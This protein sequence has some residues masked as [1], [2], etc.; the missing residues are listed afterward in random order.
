M[1]F[2]WSFSS[3]FFPKQTHT[4]NYKYSQFV[5]VMFIKL[6][7]FNFYASFQ[8]NFV[9][10]SNIRNA[11]HDSIHT[12]NS[13]Q[14]CFPMYNKMIIQSLFIISK[15]KRRLEKKWMHLHTLW[16]KTK[17][18]RYMTSLM[19]NTDQSTD[20]IQGENEISLVNVW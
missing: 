18:L 8:L 11:G 1:L 16:C 19:I 14:S 13:Y 10:T 12:N 3:F 6:F 15:R 2:K 7:F 20:P 9:N 17:T 4:S 5:F